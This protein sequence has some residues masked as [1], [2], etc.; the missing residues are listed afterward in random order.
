MQRTRDAAVTG[1][2]VSGE[3]VGARVDDVA[4]GTDAEL[5]ATQSSARLVEQVGHVSRAAEMPV[6]T[7]H[8]P[9]NPRASVARRLD[10]DHLIG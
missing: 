4:N 8:A 3:I 1:V 5:A 6:V 10:R 7:C 2:Q 9:T